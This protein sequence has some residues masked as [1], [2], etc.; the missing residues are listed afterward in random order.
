[1]RTRPLALAATGLALTAVLAACGSGS[2]HAS[3]KGATPGSAASSSPT[4]QAADV[5]FAQLMVPHHQQAIEM[6]GLALKYGSSAKVKQLATQIKGAQDPEIAHM[7]QWLQD[8]GAPMTM[9]G[10][11]ASGMPGSDHSGHDMGGVGMAGM[12]TSEEM[13]SLAHARGT[14][15]DR[16]WLQMM[17][18]HHQGAVT[19]AQQVLDTTSDPQ[20][21]ALANAVLD[22]QTTEIDTMQKL[23]AG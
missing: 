13:A 21:T 3:M 17:I 1:M 11:E 2:E 14:D 6:A 12:M 10:S 7:T 22:G 8:W 23:L 16:M 5:A 18:A 4:G 19:M 15:F 20:V 9:P